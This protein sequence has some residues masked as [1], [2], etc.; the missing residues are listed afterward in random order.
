MEQFIRFQ[1]GIRTRVELLLCSKF[2]NHEQALLQGLDRERVHTGILISL[3]PEHPYDAPLGVGLVARLR[4]LDFLYLGTDLGGRLFAR[5]RNL[6][7]VGGIVRC[8]MA[9][10]AFDFL[11]VIVG[12]ATLDRG[13]VVH[14]CGIDLV[15]RL[16]GLALLGLAELVPRR[17][18]DFIVALDG[19]RLRDGLVLFD[20]ILQLGLGWSAAIFLLVG[21]KC[22]HKPFHQCGNAGLL[23][24]KVAHVHI[25]VFKLLDEPLL[26]KERL[27]PFNQVI[28]VLSFQRHVVDCQGYRRAGL[29]ERIGDTYDRFGLFAIQPHLE[30]GTAHGVITALA[31]GTAIFGWSI[32]FLAGPVI[33]GMVD[34]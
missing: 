19:L 17:A 16:G 23:Q 33:R 14:Y 11:I 18:Q 28:K 4:V 22:R 3:I 9:T 24:V 10:V 25:P 20:E 2:V 34:P 32:G 29:H 13:F 31:D 5:G 15:D 7:A 12:L 6:S 8:T 26:G 21:A 1:F 30:E 27:V